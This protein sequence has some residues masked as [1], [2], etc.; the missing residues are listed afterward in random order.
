MKPSTACVSVSAAG[1]GRGGSP[2]RRRVRP[3]SQVSV[4]AGGSARMPAKA[5]SSARKKPSR[6]KTASASWSSS[7]G[8]SAGSSAS[9][10]GERASEA[11]PDR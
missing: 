11:P 5:V 2:C 7:A 1:P 9:G 10:S 8:P 3:V 4:A 6:R